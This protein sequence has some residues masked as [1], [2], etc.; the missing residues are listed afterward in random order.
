MNIDKVILRGIFI[1]ISEVNKYQQFQYGI[2]NHS[3]IDTYNLFLKFG[4]AYG[5]EIKVEDWEISSIKYNL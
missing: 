4:Y 2:P 1:G 3:K 5:G